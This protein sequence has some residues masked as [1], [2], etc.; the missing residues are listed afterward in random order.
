MFDCREPG[1]CAVVVESRLNPVRLDGGDI[2]S[3]AACGCRHQFFLRPG[4]LLSLASGGKTWWAPAEFTGIKIAPIIFPK[5]FEDARE[6]GA[7]LAFVESNVPFDMTVRGPHS[8]ALAIP[9]W[10]VP[11]EI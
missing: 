3:S 8:V 5:L 10:S 2:P 11:R 9:L 4:V 7:T 6:A 1:G